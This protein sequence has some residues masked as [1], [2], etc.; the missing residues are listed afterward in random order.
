M[1]STFPKKLLESTTMRSLAL[2]VTACTAL[3]CQT[4]PEAPQSEPTPLPS[5]RTAIMTPRAA[6]FNREA[7]RHK[8]AA[9][10][11]RGES[12]AT[13]DGGAIS[14]PGLPLTLDDGGPNP[15]LWNEMHTGAPPTDLRS[16]VLPPPFSPTCRYTPATCPSNIPFP[17]RCAEARAAPPTCATETVNADGSVSFC[18]PLLNAATSAAEGAL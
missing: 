6:A 16:A 15:P 9:I 1:F 12:Q 8:L 3:G 17:L 7:R 13:M 2:V 11:P 5:A 4:E 18:C 10:A 14:G